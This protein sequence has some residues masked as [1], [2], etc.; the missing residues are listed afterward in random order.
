[1]QFITESRREQVSFLD[2]FVVKMCLLALLMCIFAHLYSVITKLK[3]PGR[4][5]QYHLIFIFFKNKQISQGEI[6]VKEESNQ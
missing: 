6:K 3:T 4:W 1:M 2:T 5:K